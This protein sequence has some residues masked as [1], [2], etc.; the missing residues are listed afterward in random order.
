MKIGKI[1]AVAALLLSTALANAGEPPKREFRSVWM[2]AMG[3]D[4]PR[5]D[6]QGTSEKDRLDAQASLIEYLDNFKRH[7]F[8]GICLQ[9]R[10][11][12][13]A[14]YRSTLE[15]WSASVSGERGVDPGW[16]PLQFAI[17]ECHKRGLEC[18]AWINPFRITNQGAIYSTDF[19]LEWREKGWELKSGK[20]TIFNMAIPE[21]RQHCLDVIKEIYTNYSVDGLI[22]DDYF[23]PDDKLA[24]GPSAG[25]YQIWK[26]AKT[27]LSIADWR[28]R[29]VNEFV[30]E[31]YEMIQTDRPDMHY[32]IGP[33]GT[34]GASSA[35]HGVKPP[36]AG[37]DWQYDKIYA[38][39]LAWLHEGTI[40]F[41]SPQIYWSRTE[42][43]AYFKPVAEWWA[44]VADH[45]GRHNYV[46]MASYKVETAAF[47]GNN[48][49]GWNEFVAQIDL[50]RANAEDHAPGQIYFSAAQFD[51]P[52]L[53]GLGDWLGEHSYQRPALIPPLTWKEHTVYGAP[54]GATVDANGK[55][56]WNPVSV[57][58]DNTIM[59]YSIYA[60][61]MSHSLEEASQADGDGID[62]RC[63]VDVSYATEFILP[64]HLRNNYWYAIC[65]YD[66]Y[67]FEYA[68][69]TVN[70]SGERSV[71][72]S[73]LTPEAD[74]VVDW[75]AV[76]TWDEV[77]GAGY[78]VELS[79]MPDFSSI[80]MMQ[81]RLT[82]PTATFDLSNLGNNSKLYWRVAVAEPGKL[83]NYTEGRPFYSPTRQVADKATPLQPADGSTLEAGDINLS[84][85]PAKNAERYYLEI[86]RDTDFSVP[87]YSTYV[88]APETS[89]TVNS[90][91]L[92]SGTFYWRVIVHGRRVNS[93]ISDAFSF[94][95]RRGQ[96]GDI[97]EGYEVTVDP[98]TAPGSIAVTNLWYRS[99]AGGP[100]TLSFEGEG[101][102][103]RS[104]AAT[105]DFVYVTERDANSRTAAATLRQYDAF[106]GE[107]IRD[108]QLTGI[109]NVASWPCNQ[110]VKDSRNNICI[111]D[112]SST[113][114]SRPIHLGL[115]N[116]ATGKVTEV[117]EL[118]GRTATSTR[119]DYA[120]V[121]GDVTSELFYVFA[122]CHNKGTLIRWTVEDGEVTE[123]QTFTTREF[124][125]KASNFGT[126]PRI[127]PID[128]NHCYVDGSAAP[129]AVYN[130]ATGEI[131]G[132][133]AQAPG[134]M[135]G[136]PTSDNGIVE[137]TVN[138]T[139]V[140][141]FNSGAAA[142]GSSYT[143]ATLAAGG[144]DF[145]TLSTFATVP[146]TAFGTADNADG[147]S[148]IDFVKDEDGY[149]RVYVYSPGN[150]LAC[151]AVGDAAAI[152][153]IENGAALAI[154]VHG[155]RA[156]FAGTAALVTVHTVSGASVITAAGVDHVDLP[157]P[158][159][160][161]ITAD[162]I[163]RLVLAR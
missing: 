20:W 98:V 113:V 60:V 159:A 116:L 5:N 157:A 67:G 15:P 53:W 106:T 84:W 55:L 142:K 138:N 91:V 72:T 74:A 137:F 89:H 52:D 94:T 86:S 14:L 42:G 83:Y 134:A 136:V 10:P 4:W 132:S 49:K 97:E 24:E 80:L 27:G 119:V 144:R 120:A 129:A 7:N 39:P 28:R 78:V 51:G 3:I 69:A 118:K 41:I 128:E 44:Y 150:G 133:L 154:S 93:S 19:D 12:A 100:S 38:D 87:V 36:T 81:D 68:P 82:E 156:D 126:A 25:D 35:L 112:Q 71:S 33:A 43:P 76:F 66:G 92:G 149:V 37:S 153:D 56:S 63:L 96:P 30:A 16:D 102:F 2:A 115:V 161:I 22:F 111:F 13:D 54:E 73:L 123:T 17:E 135:E 90:V 85:Q 79:T 29:N 124:V 125:G 61:P 160:Y 47:G 9:V 147:S 105:P 58:R 104:M 18:Y 1:V 65:V 141:V 45:F 122:V 145:S 31:L 64:E 48:E 75:D 8:T 57:E 162:G 146:A 117:A 158:G 131:K 101:S 46:S 99:T 26:D 127:F 130:F 151:Y 139:P 110:V 108:L 23:Y 11:M 21:A 32:G 95:V 77:P 121:Y 40:D 34:A 148:P 163:S 109:E 103:H 88:L 62:G 59:R 143:L 107:H 140:V 6:C 70:Y 155:L 50:G 114:T 152:A